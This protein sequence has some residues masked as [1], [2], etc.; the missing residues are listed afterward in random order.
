MELEH[1]KCA[2]SIETP[3]STSHQGPRFVFACKV[4]MCGCNLYLR[5]IMNCSPGKPGA[6][7]YE[8][9][10]GSKDFQ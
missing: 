9:S 3:T 8:Q 10:P 2:L 4:K 5:V 1:R 7:M 6:P